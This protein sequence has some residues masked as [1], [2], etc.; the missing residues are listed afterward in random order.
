MPYLYKKSI[1]FFDLFVLILK[2][3]YICHL[4]ACIFHFIG[5]IEIENGK[6]SWLDYYELKDESVGIKYLTCVYF[7]VVTIS[8]IGN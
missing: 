5:I 1:I 6:P 7:N 8:T 3:L 2:I 4:Y